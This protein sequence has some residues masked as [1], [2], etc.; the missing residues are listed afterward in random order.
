ML[1]PAPGRPQGRDARHH[2]ALA[3]VNHSVPF[4]HAHASRS[5]CEGISRSSVTSRRRT[6]FPRRRK[7]RVAKFTAAA[8]AT[9]Q[10]TVANLGAQLRQRRCPTYSRVVQ[11]SQRP[12][13]TK[14]TTRRKFTRPVLALTAVLATAAA[15]SRSHQHRLWRR[16][17]RLQPGQ[18]FGDV[19]LRH[20]ADR[21]QHRRH[22]RVQQSGRDTVGRRQ[23]RA[24]T[25]LRRHPRLSRHLW[26]RRHPV[27]RRLLSGDG[28]LAD[29]VP[30]ATDDNDAS[31][32][33]PRRGS[34]TSPTTPITTSSLSPAYQVWRSE[35]YSSDR[36]HRRCRQA[37]NR[38]YRQ[39]TP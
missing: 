34:A 29:Y 8:S 7:N 3:G 16:R 31:S 17:R 30:P 20:A 5:A 38:R 23:D 27:L 4:R 21:H 22:D 24:H 28:H 9:E 6:R 36:L 35:A 37:R 19:T 1:S 2:Q 39:C 10:Y 26:R 14:M 25:A 12:G 32:A 18:Y 33:Y 15:A 13:E 11:P